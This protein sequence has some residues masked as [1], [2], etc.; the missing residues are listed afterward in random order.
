[1]REV[2]MTSANAP[3][4]IDMEVLQQLITDQQ[5]SK[6]AGPAMPTT[7][8]RAPKATYHARGREPV[9]LDKSTEAAA[10]FWAEFSP[11]KQTRQKTL[12]K[13]PAAT[14]VVPSGNQTN[15]TSIIS[16]ASAFSKQYQELKDITTAQQ[17]TINN[18]AQTSLNLSDEIDALKKAMENSVSESK[19]LH[20][21]MAL[22]AASSKT[23]HESQAENKSTL[24][25]HTTLLEKIMGKLEHLPNHRKRSLRSAQKEQ[26]T[27]QSP[28][29]ASNFTRGPLPNPSQNDD[30]DTEGAGI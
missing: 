25:S 27:P 30:M 24:T 17:A 20:D 9:E 4:D 5:L 21:A 14:I 10:T 6:F 28:E 23:V 3:A 12:G 18:M 7:Y 26:V 11:P 29:G 22:L 16:P 13:P 8:N 2:E 1:M 19:K 15:I